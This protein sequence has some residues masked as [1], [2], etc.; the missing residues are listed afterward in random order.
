MGLPCMGRPPSYAHRVLFF[1]I[2]AYGALPVGI[3]SPCG[4]GHP[5]LGIES[6]CMKNRPNPLSI[7]FPLWT[8]GLAFGHV[9]FKS[10]IFIETA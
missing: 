2:Y 10:K 6:R 7:G 3:W 5:L 1:R 9:V 8:K 4:H